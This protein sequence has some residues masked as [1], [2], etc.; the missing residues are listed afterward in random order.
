MSESFRAR[1]RAYW[2]AAVLARLRI[3]QIMPLAGW[4]RIAALA[5]I[6]LVL[7]LLPLVF[8]LA[9]S[10]MI[11]GV[12]NAVSGGVGSHAWDRVVE[13]FLIAAAAFVAG[14]ILA[15]VQQMIGLAVQRAVD[16]R[17]RD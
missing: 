16:G 8:M 11:G 5:T 4:W 3:W 6:S 17:V 15:P 2:E 13:L 7:G 9:T 10:A 14:Q 12:P 1:R